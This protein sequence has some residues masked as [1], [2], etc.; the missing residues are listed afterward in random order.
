MRPTG[1]LTIFIS[2]LLSILFMIAPV[3]PWLSDIWPIWIIPVLAYWVMALP[4]RVGFLT[5]WFFGL[6]L[7]TLNNTLLGI[8][9]LAL[10]IIAALFAK[11]ARQFSFFSTIQQALCLMVF[12]GLYVG[13][14]ALA[15]LY[16]DQEVNRMFWWPAVTTGLVWPLISG[17]LRYYRQRFRLT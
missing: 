5:A 10:L 8:H 16:N 2:L 3:A 6:L 17:M 4:H 13:A 1:W 11:I 12:S 9:A 7:D 15:Q 14:L